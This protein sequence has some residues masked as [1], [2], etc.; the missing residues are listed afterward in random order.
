M[1]V[2]VS[3]AIRHHQWMDVHLYRCTSIRSSRNAPPGSSKESST[4]C[5]EGQS[6]SSYAAFRAWAS[7]P[8]QHQRTLCPP[9]ADLNGLIAITFI[10]SPPSHLGAICLTGPKKAVF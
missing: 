6:P 7:Q 1:G 8:V 9:G 5:L 10:G 2:E 3:M 4:T